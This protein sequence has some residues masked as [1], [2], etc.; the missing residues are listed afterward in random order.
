MS[1]DKFKFSNAF[2]ADKKVLPKVSINIGACL[3]IPTCSL[4]IGAK[5]EIIYNGGLANS[6]GMVGRGNNYKSTILHYMELQAM[7]RMIEATGLNIPIELQTYDTECNISIDRLEDLSSGMEFIPSNPITDADIW[8]VTDKSI[9]TGDAWV[10]KLFSFMDLKSSS[11]DA[12]IEYQ[13]FKDPY[14]PNALKLPFPSFIEIDSL[15]EF[16]A[17]STT[18]MLSSG[19][20]DSNTNTYAMKQGGFKS[21]VFSQLPAR[22][23]GSNSYLGVTAQL[24]KGID[25]AGPMKAPEPKKLQYLKQGEE[26]KGATGKF[27]FLTLNAFIANNAAKLTNPTTKKAE[28]PLDN[29]A[30]SL[31]TELNTVRLTVL[32]SKFG[33]SGTNITIIVSQHTGVDPQ[34]TEFYNIKENGKYGIGGNDRSYY[35]ELMPDV[36]LS[37]TTIRT[38]INESKQLRR[39]IN[40]ASEMQQL[41]LYLGNHPYVREAMCTPK[42][43]YEDI[44]ALGYDWDMLLRTREYWTINQYDNK[45]PYLNTLDLMRMRIGK[46]TPYF[47]NEDKTLKTKYKS[48]MES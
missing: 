30:D 13:C 44:K 20:D 2:G 25:M 47:L 17:K 48:I 15:S 16:E 42:E 19:L 45:V 12:L 37:R 14:G 9:M 3:D 39:A 32:R 41:G 40:I 29:K 6:T 31:E 22:V 5:G 46:Y 24:G 23:T 11:K 35:I 36:T 10:D 43:L 21:K 34:L 1:L 28:F 27:N 18:E 8:M 38:K 7:N 26:I 33:P 4:V